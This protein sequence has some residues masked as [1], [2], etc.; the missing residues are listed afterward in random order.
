MIQVARRYR[1]VVQDTDR[2]GNVRTYLRLPDQPKLRLHETPGTDAF[3]AEY[4]RAVEAPP[5]GQPAR[6]REVAKGTLDELFI[7]Y[8][9]GS[10]FKRMDARS[11][12]VRRLILERFGQAIG[13]DGKRHGDRMAATLPPSFLERQKDMRAE[14]PEGFNSLLKALRAVYKTGIRVGA[15]KDSP[16][17][18]VAYLPSGN[19]DGFHAWTAEE[20]AQFE[21]H[22]PVGSKPRLA[23]ALLMYLGV[24]RSDAVRLGR[25]HLRNGAVHFRVQKGRTKTPKDLVLPVVPV[26]ARII[27]A[28]PCGEL[29]FLVN[30]HGRPYSAE[31]FGNAFRKWCREAGLPQ[32]SPH[33]LRKVASIRLAH[34][35]ATEHELMG[36]MGWSSPKQAALYTRNAQ[37]DR[38]AAS[39]MARLAADEKSHPTPARAEWDENATEATERTEQNEPMVPRAG[40]EPAT[41]RFSVA[42]S[43]N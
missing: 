30:D 28:S 43:T 2:H 42:C 24:R 18:R 13:K 21:A 37:Q 1:Y 35:G 36:A 8:F 22:W 26:L 40:I 23:L 14:T 41:L 20:V 11:Q 17:A 6:P 15:V 33:G 39:A 5:A 3:D 29:H 31:T 12:R 16:A 10:E 38:L 19:P 34:L 9:G 4:R 25:Q 7:T 32:C 27:A